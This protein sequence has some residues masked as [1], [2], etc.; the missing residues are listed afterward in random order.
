MTISTDYQ[1]DEQ[2]LIFSR[3]EPQR[4]KKNKI[5]LGQAWNSLTV[6]FKRRKDSSNR[7][8]TAVVKKISEERIQ[9]LS[10][11]H[12]VSKQKLRQKNSLGI[13]IFNSY[14][15]NK[16]LKYGSVINRAVA[17]YDT[18][19]AKYTNDKQKARPESLSARDRGDHSIEG[20]TESLLMK[21]VRKSV[22]KLS[23]AKGSSQ[24]GVSFILSFKHNWDI[25]AKRES[26][27]L[28]IIKWCVTDASCFIGEGAFG[29]VHQV[30]DIANT[31]FAAMKVA[32][33]K[34][35]NNQDL[36]EQNL[37]NEVSKLTFIHRNGFVEGVMEAPFCFFYIPGKHT[38]F[39]A[40]TQKLY[41]LEDVVEVIT[42]KYIDPKLMP[43]EEG[44]LI[45]KRLYNGLKSLH[46]ESTEKGS[47]IHGDLKSDNILVERTTEGEVRCV[48]GDLGGAMYSNEELTNHKEIINSPLG[49]VTTPGSFTATD[50][51]KLRKAI[52]K[53]NH[54][55]W[56][57]YQKK[58]DLYGLT[59]A[60]W[61]MIASDK[62]YD[63]DSSFTNDFFPNTGN[64]VKH[65]SN[66]SEKYGEA[67]TAILLAAL[68]EN[69]DDRPTIHR[70]LRVIDAELNRKK[71]KIG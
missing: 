12:L 29:Y 31:Q 3:K 69:P 20:L 25:L 26:G 43:K 17:D 71:T 63:V 66:V 64:K 40:Y 44:L 9:Y 47:I 8:Q 62:P 53:K 39:I 10:S 4:K 42:N 50:W 1:S 24:L 55:L 23:E 65:L 27:R 56:I 15:E 45:L 46:R 67:V 32:L 58:R 7:L 19:R 41:N 54:P 51:K 6:T 5:K 59:V 35:D 60:L 18:I 14:L 52:K 34:E 37:M 36:A 68:S 57:Y 28:Q 49:T 30:E 48:I 16:V 13:Q 61:P 33:A 38:N 11:K 21:I 22:L 2:P 70:I